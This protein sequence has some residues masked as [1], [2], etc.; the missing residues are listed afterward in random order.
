MSVAQGVQTEV[1]RILASSS[2]EKEIFPTSI[3]D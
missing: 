3:L 2:L 1:K